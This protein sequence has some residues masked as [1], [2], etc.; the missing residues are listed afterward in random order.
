MLPHQ[1]ATQF[2]PEAAVMEYKSGKRAIPPG[3]FTVNYTSIEDHTLKD[4]KF[5]SLP[6]ST[7]F[8]YLLLRMKYK[9][10]NADK[11]TLTCKEAELEWGI[12]RNTLAKGLRSL[13]ETKI[14]VLVAKGG[15]PLSSSVYS[16][17]GRLWG[18]QE[19]TPPPKGI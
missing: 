8:I 13:T 9:G 18:I 10:N 2:L 3:K 6:Y 16:L 19:E 4:P 17:R 1:I 11:I 7:R 5:L 15:L 14:I 12:S